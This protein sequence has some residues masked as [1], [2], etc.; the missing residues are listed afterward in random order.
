MTPFVENREI[1][2]SNMIQPVPVLGCGNLSVEG[3][4]NRDN[5]PYPNHCHVESS[6]CSSTQRVFNAGS[7]R[8][9]QWIDNCSVARIGVEW[10]LWCMATEC[11]ELGC[12]NAERGQ[13]NGI[14]PFPTVKLA[15]EAYCLMFVIWAWNCFWQPVPRLACLTLRAADTVNRVEYS[16]QK[17]L[18][19]IMFVIWAW[20]CFW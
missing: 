18:G 10:V 1:V 17:Y 8:V 14:V 15:P 13:F 5:A 7:G 12:G 6:L 4:A 20:N 16:E 11:L 2:I 9:W 19:H 3:I